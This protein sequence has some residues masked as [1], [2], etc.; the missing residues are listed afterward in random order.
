MNRKKLGVIGGLGPMA[1]ALFLQ[2]VVEM[3]E[4]DRDQEHIEMF[5]HHCPQIPDRT[6]FILGKSTENPAPALIESGIKLA[7]Q[8]ADMIV[9]PCVTSTYF[10]EELSSRIPVPVLNIVTQIRNYLYE[11]QIRSVGLMATSGTVTSGLFQQAFSDGECRLI[12]PSVERQED[13]MHLIYE[14]VKAGKPV[15]MQRFHRVQQELF[16]CGAEVI[17]LGCTE[18]SLI[19]RDE[20]IGP[21]FLDVMEVLARETVIRSGKKLKSKYKTLLKGG[22]VHAAQYSGVS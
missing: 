21:G 20:N 16:D 2:M 14:N 11:H 4:A 6:G 8:G 7:E 10:Y 22:D 19:K 15:D 12:L 18:L 13:V 5:I 17:L 3:T 9:I 1:T